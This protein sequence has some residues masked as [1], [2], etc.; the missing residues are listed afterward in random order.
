MFVGV[1]DASPPEAGAPPCLSCHPPVWAGVCLENG[2]PQYCTCG[3]LS[4]SYL[5]A[6]TGKGPSSLGWAGTQQGVSR[7]YSSQ[8]LA[9]FS[10]LRFF[11][12]FL[13]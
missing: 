8:L 12:F 6:Q 10:Y 2:H 1:Q 13:Q 5:S 11:F 7:A 4:W 9:S 3:G